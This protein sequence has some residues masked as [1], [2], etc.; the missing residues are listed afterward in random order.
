MNIFDQSLDLKLVFGHR[1]LIP[2]CLTMIWLLLP[3]LVFC[4]FL[5][6]WIQIFAKDNFRKICPCKSSNC[7]TETFQ[8]AVK[9]RLKQNNPVV[10]V[11]PRW[12]HKLHRCDTQWDPQ[13]TSNYNSLWGTGYSNV[14]IIIRMELFSQVGETVTSSKVLQIDR[15]Y[16]YSCSRFLTRKVLIYTLDILK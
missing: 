3:P 16:S 8:A 14:L 7:P 6:N 11:T 1:P 2:Q 12:G 9:P 5:F 13:P 4:L 10:A 15:A